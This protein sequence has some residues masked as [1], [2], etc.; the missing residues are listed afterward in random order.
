MLNLSL[1]ALSRT[2]RVLK[3]T[4]EVVP[5]RP[6]SM[7]FADEDD[8]DEVEEEL[9]ALSS[10]YDADSG[11][12]TIER[13]GAK[14]KGAKCAT[15][16]YVQIKPF[17][18]GANS[19]ILVKGTL[20]LSL[21]E[22]YPDEEIPKIEIVKA[23]GLSDEEEKDCRNRLIKLALEYVGEP[24][25]PLICDACQEIFTE[26]NQ[27]DC[28]ICLEKLSDTH[29]GTRTGCFHAF[30]ETCLSEYY[31]RSRSAKAN[32]DTGSNPG[33]TLDVDTIDKKIRELQG[34]IGDLAKRQK[35]MKKALGKLEASSRYL[36]TR[37]KAIG[38]LKRKLTPMEKDEQ[39][40]L[41]L[42]HKMTLVEIDEHK[43]E[44]KSLKQDLDKLLWKRKELE[45]KKAKVE[46]ASKTM[47]EAGFNE[48]FSLPCP[49]CRTGI[50]YSG[51]FENVLQ[52]AP[53]GHPSYRR[54]GKAISTYDDLAGES[55]K[56]S[57]LKGDKVRKYVEDIQL[58][59]RM[60][61]TKLNSAPD[62]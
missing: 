62:T 32:V 1:S 15:T 11:E 54:G 44:N 47:L 19:R 39:K 2:V 27:A 14:G 46:K 50:S 31:L 6:A 52:N 45:I 48:N 26:Y 3:A 49:V 57:S 53:D 4:W 20:K 38:A 30:H 24:C 60:L 59:H 41:E 17:T 10:I 12:I 22:K 18:G 43:A 40:Q 35:D 25:L 51:F 23:K 33:D 34:K 29:V 61:K 16:V 9:L 13:H 21:G 7:E 5:L 58:A 8:F 37:C 56:I 42:K 28:G 36:E 55:S